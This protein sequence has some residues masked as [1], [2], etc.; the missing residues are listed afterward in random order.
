MCWL[1]P[2][3]SFTPSVPSLSE[4]RGQRVAFN[5]GGYWQSHSSFAT[6]QEYE[7]ALDLLVRGS[8]L[9]LADAGAEG[10]LG[11]STDPFGSHWRNCLLPLWDWDPAAGADPDWHPAVLQYA[12]LFESG[13]D[14]NYT[15]GC[16]SRVPELTLRRCADLVISNYAPYSWLFSPI[17]GGMSL[18]FHNTTSFGVCLPEAGSDVGVLMRKLAPLGLE[19]CS[20]G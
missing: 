9:V 20:V 5:I 1:E 15:G 16:I 19:A 2:D 17:Q 3:P 6:D 18:Y 12:H 7:V 13:S 11:V 14:W 8:W 4:F 10:V